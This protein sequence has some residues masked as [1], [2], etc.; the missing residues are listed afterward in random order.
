[1]RELTEK[2]QQWDEEGRIPQEYVDLGY[3][4]CS[5]LDWALVHR[6]DVAAVCRCYGDSADGEARDEE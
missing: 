5:E 6:A 3:H 2:L 4:F 1:M